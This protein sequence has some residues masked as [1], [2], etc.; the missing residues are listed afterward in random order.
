MKTNITP[1]E[2][3]SAFEAA[4]KKSFMHF[5]RGLTIPSARGPVLFEMV[6]ADFQRKFFEDIAPSLHALRD[7]EMPPHRRFWLERTK[8]TA[9]DA[10]VAI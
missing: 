7:G 1:T 3:D 9:K 2:I 10:D 5:A 4:S 8:K 6:M